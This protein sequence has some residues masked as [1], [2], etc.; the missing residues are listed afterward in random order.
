M[1]GDPDGSLDRLQC[2]YHALAHSLG[3]LLSRTGGSDR[4]S[5]HHARALA[6][7]R[8]VSAPLEEARA[9]EGIGQCH[10][11]N[12]DPGQAAA[13]LRQALAIY[14]RIGAPHARRVQETLHRHGLPSTTREPQPTAPSREGH[15]PPTPAPPG[16]R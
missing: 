7:T 11:Q 6:L 10:I 16:R 2:A 9:L 15:R 14:Q 1:L 5:G 3:E 4:A 13:Y 12:D 8:D